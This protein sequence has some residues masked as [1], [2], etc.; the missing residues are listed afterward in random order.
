MKKSSLILCSSWLHGKHS[1]SVEINTKL[2]YVAIGSFYAQ[3]DEAQ[4]TI[5]EINFIYNSK[6]LNQLEACLE[7]ASNMGIEF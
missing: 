5:D 4:V 7:W 1:D 2:P 3:G 6:N